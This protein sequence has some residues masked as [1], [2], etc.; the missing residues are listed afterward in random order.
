VLAV[1][2]AIVFVSMRPSGAPA[3][4][5]QPP[6]VTAETTIR[7]FAPVA[8]L[9]PADLVVNPRRPEVAMTATVEAPM[10]RE[11]QAIRDDTQAAIKSVLSPLPVEMSGFAFR[12]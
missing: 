11:A 2:A 8:D 6:L 1:G 5:L 9:N 4:P 3:G 10:L 7:V 12:P